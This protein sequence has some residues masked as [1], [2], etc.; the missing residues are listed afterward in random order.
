MKDFIKKIKK[1]D[2]KEM[3]KD[4][5]GRAKIELTAYLLFFIGV[6]IF[7]RVSSSNINNNIDNSFNNT[8]S[9]INDIMDNYEDNVSI[10]INNNIYTYQIIRLGNNTKIKRKENDNEKFYYIMND[11]Y[12]E[13]DNNGNYILTTKEEVYP[14]LSYNYLNIDN[15]KNFISFGTKEDNSYIIKISDIILNSNS[16]D[17]IIITINEESKSIMIDYTNLLKID[18]ANITI[19]SVNMVFNNINKIISLEE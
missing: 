6:V 13:L 8:N 12:Y 2:L 16:D 15:I 5:K 1:I 9:F 7:A 4:K 11:K 19:A 17:S 3:W 18:D 10:N 14:Y